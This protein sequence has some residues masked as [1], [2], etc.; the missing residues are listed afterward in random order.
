[1]K[2]YI[3]LTL[4]VFG[5]IGL[6]LF[7]NLFF[8]KIESKDSKDSID[9]QKT[10]NIAILKP[11][12]HPAL[13]NIEDSF[14]NFLN[15]TEPDRYVFK[16][17]NANGNKILLRSQV[18][19]I[20]ACDVDLIFTIAT[21]ATQ[22]V[23]ELIKKKNKNIPI[24]FTAVNDPEK[25]G[26]IS[27]DLSK[28]NTT[29][30][31]EVVDYEKEIS[32]FLD[33]KPSAKNT[34]LVYNP[35]EGSGLE[36]DKDTVKRVLE[37]NGI[38]VTIMEVYQSNEIFTKV[39]SI[40]SDFDSLI[41]LKDNTVVSAI[42]ALVKLCNRYSV[43]LVASDL[44]SGGKGAAFSFG[45]LESEFGTKAAE[46]VNKILIEG[47]SFQVVAPVDLKNYKLRINKKN[48][49]NQNLFLDKKEMFLIES[50]E[51]I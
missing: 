45:V 34:L 19:E 33:L 30:I 31:I 29:G 20:V 36:K 14:I 23:T 13:D 26:I 44:D 27:S 22:I 6:F 38:D 48:M 40:I 2:K 18:E 28:N 1:M 21:G 5:L 39:S 49:I 9:K 3:S 4:F 50:A 11:I 12:S 16:Q 42:D 46:M 17:Y 10:F 15:K 37:S 32:L 25:L 43:T 41:V 7:N 8:V 35:S 51:A 24:V 47:K